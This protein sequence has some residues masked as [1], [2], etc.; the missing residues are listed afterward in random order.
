[1]GTLLAKHVTCIL[2]GMA[3][4]SAWA[5]DCGPYQVL[6]LQ[7]QPGDALVHLSDSS[8]TYWKSLGAWS[9][10]STKPYLALAMQASATQRAVYLRYADPYVCATTDYS[11]T[12]QMLRV[13]AAQ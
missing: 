5:V 13:D 8:G 1:M 7:A 9:Q 11:S 12:P 10:P 3:F 6:H 4:Q 2:V